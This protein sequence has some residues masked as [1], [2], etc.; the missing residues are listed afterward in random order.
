MST[1]LLAATVLGGNPLL[2][3]YK[4]PHQTIP[5]NEIKTENYFPAFEEAMKQHMVEIATIINNSESPT[6]ENTIVALEKSG[7]L[8]TKVSSPFYN[9]LGSE[10]TDDLQALAEKISPLETEHANSIR[11]NEKLFAR[12]KAV[13]L[14]KD[15][16]KL[17]PE[18]QILLKQ[19]Y[20]GF[21]NNGANLSEPDK[22]IYRELSKNL[23]LLTLQYGQNVLR[24]TNQYKL[25]ITKKDSLSGLPS[26]LLDM[27]AAN[28]KNAGQEGWLLNLKTT[29]YVPVMK[30]ADNRD[31]RREL[32]MA[33]S[34]KCM[35]G[36]EFDNREN[37]K[38]IVNTRLMI[39]N[40]LGY[41]SFA[42]YE[43][44]DRMAENKENV[45]NLLDKL[46]TAYK[47][48]AEK[49]YAEV[50][51][52]ANRNG[53]YFKIQPW[54][55]SY[56]SE[57]LKD[58]KFLVN[59]EMLKPYFELESVKKGVFGLATRLYGIQFIKNSKI[60]VYNKEVDAYD[61]TDE[62]GKFIAVL[63]TDF[64]PRDG[65]RAGAWMNDFKAQWMDGK[66]DSRPQIT[67]VMNFTRPTD[68]KPALLTFDE[69]KTFLHEFGHSLHGMLTKC[70][71]QSLS[72]TN[73]Y[74]DFVE[75]PSQIM[76]N[77]ASEKEFLDGFAK[78]YQTGE[79]IPADLIQK[80]KDSENFN[81]AYFCLRQLSFGY[82]DM[83]WHTIEKPF[84]GDVI[85]YETKA[86]ASTQILPIVS[87][88][89][90]STTF[91]HIFAGGYA[92][93]YYSYKWAEVLD[94]DA[95]SVFAKNGIFDKET[96]ESF[97]KNIL[98][99]GGTE[100][101]MILYKRFR[102]Q[103]PTIDAILKRDGINQE[104]TGSKN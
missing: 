46:L 71:Y 15:K 38:K 83:A 29:C 51:E 4:T 40:L 98:E 16:L 52:Y 88:T 43:L 87:N 35:S 89:G 9:L 50:Q 63:Y 68:S 36:G 32:Y 1:I 18:Q 92:A 12:V 73:V 27:L 93:G 48:T 41:K 3:T 99:K 102:G 78:H 69:V 2:E 79:K 100:N 91:S 75:L 57:K 6:F 64:H 20:E 37:V 47:P 86:M 8:L 25:L 67:L 66:T 103:E 77:W 54:D 53:A 56:Y 14:Q 7:S 96:A 17:T 44:I 60:Q 74:R 42:D 28:A 39:A 76:E 62:N 97:R 90:M 65:K 72:G 49:E 80:I 31:L 82:L 45:Y 59:D 26:D 104:S 19:T 95:F 58:E 10:T 94:A 30:Y 21:A 23:S 81:N 84:D 22:V 34:S 24:E 85:N 55:W 11:L 101:P 70:T 5:F 33:Y 61:V 13:Y